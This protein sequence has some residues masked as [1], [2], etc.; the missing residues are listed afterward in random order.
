MNTDLVS[1]N[2]GQLAARTAAG[3]A[4]VSR[5]IAFVQG[6][7]ISARNFPRDQGH[8]LKRIESAC[9]NLAVAEKAM[10]SYPRG[11]QPVT[12]PSIRLA[13][14]I[15]QNWGNA[16]AGW[17]VLDQTETTTTIQVWAVDLETN[18]RDTIEWVVP[19]ERHTKTSVTKLTDPRD[20]YEA[21]ANIASRRKR[22]CIEN[23]IPRHVFQAA[24]ARAEHTLANSGDMD[25]K[26]RKLVDAFKKLDVSGDDIEL[27]IGKKVNAMSATDLVSLTK[28]Y[29]AMSDGMSDKSDWFKGAANPEKIR[30]ESEAASTAEASKLPQEK[31]ADDEAK[32]LAILNLNDAID[33]F[34]AKGGDID[35]I[36]SNFTNDQGQVLKWGLDRIKAATD[37]VNQKLKGMK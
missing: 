2:P 15:I 37:I 3:A 18:F 4:L 17:R 8:A 26:R 20:I 12:G 6:Q 11:G 35:K 16:D 23:V 27:R 21:V 5:E 34:K 1:S 9:E 33:A 22:R 24:I 32:D 28:I 19:H 25:Q 10:Y 14:V 31:R 13:E 29:Q 30:K 7:I 36:I